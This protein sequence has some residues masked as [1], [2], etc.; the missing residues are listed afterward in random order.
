MGVTIYSSVSVHRVRSVLLLSAYLFP[1]YKIVVARWQH[2][3]PV[4]SL[5]STHPTHRTK[6]R[7]LLV[8]PH[9]HLGRLSNRNHSRDSADGVLVVV[10]LKYLLL[11]G[12]QGLV[13]PALSVN[14]CE[15]HAA[16]HKDISVLSPLDVGR[17]D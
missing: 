4:R 17:L 3:A 13:L 11:L 15:S 12:G 2:V 6:W 7:H 8:V 14:G 16:G 10:H 9:R 5:S 1:I